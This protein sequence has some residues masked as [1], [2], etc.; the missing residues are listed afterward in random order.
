MVMQSVVSG[1]FGT[2]ST[3]MPI[4]SPKVDTSGT[5]FES[6]LKSSV[7]AEISKQDANK[8]T[9]D[10]S[11]SKK[12]DTKQ[13]KSTDNT[14]ASKD[15]AT[16]SSTGTKQTNSTKETAVTEETEMDTEIM[17]KVQTLIASCMQ[18]IQDTLQIS[19]EELEGLMNDLNLQPEELFTQDGLTQI[20][21]EVKG[22]SDVTDLL[23]DANAAS[24]LNK[25]LS[26][27][28]TVVEESN[29]PVTKEELPVLLE[30]FAKKL[31]QI[32]VKED[33]PN[34][35]Q[36][37]KAQK[38]EM[39]VNADDTN[40]L[41]TASASEPT[42]EV[43][44]SKT[45]SETEHRDS[46]QEKQEVTVNSFVEHLAAKSQADEMVPE[47][48]VAKLTQ[49][50]EIV[51]QIVE[52][53]RVELT[54]GQ[55]NLQLHLNPESLGR[56]QIS[57]TSKDGVMSAHFLVQNETAKDAIESQ[58]NTLIKTFD[59]QGVKVEAVEVNVSDFNFNS[60]GF[61]QQ[62]NGG[63]QSNEHHSQTRRSITLE[64]AM[65]FDD[66]T[67]D[68]QMI[69]DMMEQNGNQVDYTA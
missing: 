20:F 9:N 69:V 24:E 6:T 2:I 27:V 56:V 16:A 45:Q 12:V 37:V 60:N 68:E 52:H 66:L 54:D 41:N 10:T 38:N 47:V 34:V 13:T 40:S 28:Q 35:N 3:S 31:E 46:R 11:K 15:T 39:N 51:S 1:Q 57:L 49:Y 65:E 50:R 32:S 42:I 67:E 43:H 23:T 21:M 59:E 30:S 26:S 53:I 18:V 63:E 58:M 64:D 55:T 44:S 36:P 7:K 19:S 62:M 29:L 5:S 48:D 25:L 61:E 14:S 17:E 33:N 4:S 22:L 8:A